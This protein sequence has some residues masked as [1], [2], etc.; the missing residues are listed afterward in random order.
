[1]KMKNKKLLLE[2][3]EDTQEVDGV[4]YTEDQR[5]KSFKG[6]IVAIDEEECGYEIGDIAVF[7]EFAGEEVFI[8]KKKYLI[9]DSEN[10]WCVMEGEEA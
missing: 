9:I 5:H 3:I 2:R 7:S 4:I 1:M 8:D 10:V 6:R